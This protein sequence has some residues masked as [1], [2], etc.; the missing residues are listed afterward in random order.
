MKKFLVT[1]MVIMF[2]VGAASSASTALID[3]VSASGSGTYN[4][5]PNPLLINHVI[6]E[7][8]TWWTSSTNVWWNGTDPVFTIDLGSIYLVEDVVVS[9]DNNDDYEVEYSLDNTTWTHLFSIDDTYGD[10]PESPGGMDTMSTDSSDGEYVSQIDFT[11]VQARYLRIFST[12][13]DNMYAVGEVEAYGQPVPIPSTIMLMGTGLL[14]LV[15]YNRKR[16]SKKGS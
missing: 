9:V 16:F 7:E 4:N 2:V 14:G 13:G 15:G 12:D 1:L 10:I 11:Q 3:A 5:S 8:G 6:P